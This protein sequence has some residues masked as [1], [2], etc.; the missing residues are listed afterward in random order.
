MLGQAGFS[1]DD[2]RNMVVADD[3][4]DAYIR[5]IQAPSEFPFKLRKF[6]RRH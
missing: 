3:Y 1:W 5:C 6:K 4:V 2:A